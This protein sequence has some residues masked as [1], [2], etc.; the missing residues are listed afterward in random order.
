MPKTKTTNTPRVKKSAPTSKPKKSTSAPKPDN[1][2]L[3]ER[4]RK[5]KEILE[6]LADLDTLD[7]A[8]NL[9]VTS[10]LPKPK[11]KTKPVIPNLE[12][13]LATLEGLSLDELDKALKS[14]PSEEVTPPDKPKTR[15]KKSLK[16]IGGLPFVQIEEVPIEEV[17]EEVPVETEDIPLQAQGIPYADLLD[18]RYMVA[19]A[20]E[21]VGKNQIARQAFVGKVAS[22]IMD[23]DRQFYIG[24]SLEIPCGLGFCAEQSAIS[25]LIST[26]KSK[27]LKVVTIKDGELIPPCGR[28]RELISQIND[29]NLYTKFFLSNNRVLTLSELSGELWDKDRF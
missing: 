26:G 22:V 15:I 12:E 5:N 9:N 8:G 6:A 19:L 27:V 2:T 11:A 21:A 20:K 14:L 23:E 16:I 17:S 4:R 3:A 29:S 1:L 7:E 10:S 18:F 28:C 25:A 24:L 13:A